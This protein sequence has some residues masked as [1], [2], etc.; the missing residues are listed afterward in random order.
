VGAELIADVAEF[1]GGG[2][3]VEDSDGGGGVSIGGSREARN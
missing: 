2:H 3:E 1:D